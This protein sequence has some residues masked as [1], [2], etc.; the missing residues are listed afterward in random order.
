MIKPNLCDYSDA[1][2]LVTGDIIAQGGNVYTKVAFKNCAPF[3]RCVTHINDEHVETAENLDIIMPM[4]NLLEYSDNYESSGSLWQFKRDE[5]NLDNNGNIADVNTADSSPFKY[6]SSF[7]EIVNVAI[8]IGPLKYL[9]NFFRSLQMPLINCKIHLEL[10]W[11]KSS[12]MSTAPDDNNR[13]TTFQITSTKL[14]VSVVT[15]STENSSKI[16]KQL[17]KG[18]ERSVHWNEYKSKVET[19]PA[20]GQD[21]TRFLLDSPFQGV[22]RLLVLAFHNTNNGPNRVQRNSQ[23]KYF[24]RRVNVTKYNA[25]I[26]GRN[27]YDQPIDDQIKKYDEIRKIAVGRGDDYTTECLLDYQYFLKHYQLITVDLSKQ[28]KLDADQRAIQQ[29]EFYGMLGT[30]SKV[31]TVLEKSKETVLEFYKETAKVLKEYING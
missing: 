17:N 9:S 31:C 15:L 6:K 11:T 3:T 22:N 29:I 1:Y 19:K 7:I 13:A 27:F 4:Y 12:V 14:Y 21:V 5:R 20:D 10:N 23:K 25:S 24:L 26:D 2:I 28:K 8:I 16:I 18:S 30:N